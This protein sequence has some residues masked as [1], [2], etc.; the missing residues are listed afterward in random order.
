MLCGTEPGPQHLVPAAYRGQR[1]GW[2]TLLAVHTQLPGSSRSRGQGFRQRPQLDS[3]VLVPCCGVRSIN[4]HRC[5][6]S[7]SGTRGIVKRLRPAEYGVQAENGLRGPSCPACCHAPHEPQTSAGA[8]L[9]CSL[10]HND[11]R[12]TFAL[13]S[14]DKAF[15]FSQQ[16]AGLVQVLW[17]EDREPPWPAASVGGWAAVRDSGRG[18]EKHTAVGLARVADAGRKGEDMVG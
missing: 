13:A 4:A 14:R 12:K 6:T 8:S 11:A 9:P 5:T 18:A 17:T 2:H 15:L 16:L 10:D 1:C 7:G 3:L